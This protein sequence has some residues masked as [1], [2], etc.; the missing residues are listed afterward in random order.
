MN[1]FNMRN[2]NTN[3]TI[4]LHPKAKNI[5]YDNCATITADIKNGYH[6][7]TLIS[8]QTSLG[9][10]ENDLMCTKDKD[11]SDVVNLTLHSETHSGFITVQKAALRF[12]ITH[13]ANFFEHRDDQQMAA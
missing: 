10:L 2:L 5:Y 11:E 6:G 1:S 12:I 4:Y 13:V 9:N 3:L 8:G 7:S